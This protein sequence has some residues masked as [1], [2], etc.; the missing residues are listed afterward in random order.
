MSR[1]PNV[2][3]LPNIRA[4]IDQFKDRI[5]CKEVKQHKHSLYALHRARDEKLFLKKKKLVGVITEDEVVL[6]L[7]EHQTFATDGLYLF[8][9]RTH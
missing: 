2:R 5:T 9:V 7:D 8:R 3:A 4:Y 6:A 1:D